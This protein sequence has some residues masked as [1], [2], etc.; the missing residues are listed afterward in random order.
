[1]WILVPD[2][3]ISLASISVNS[4]ILRMPS[5]AGTYHL[6]IPRPSLLF[7]IHAQTEIQFKVFSYLNKPRLLD[8][9]AT[10]IVRQCFDAPRLLITGLV[11]LS[12]RFS[13]DSAST[14]NAC[15]CLAIVEKAKAFI[16]RF[17]QL[18]NYLQSK[19]YIKAH[20]IFLDSTEASMTMDIMLLQNHLNDSKWVHQPK[21]PTPLL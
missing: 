17:I 20:W 15:C 6:H 1:M 8:V 5:P 12:I 11:S 19:L 2:F 4:I 13:T 7:K 21:L 16:E 10:E 3:P 14:A 9:I 18:S